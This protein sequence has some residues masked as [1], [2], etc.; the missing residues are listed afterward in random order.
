[1]LSKTLEFTI[2]SIFIR[3]REKNHKFVT[4]EH[5]L[6]ALVDDPETARILEACGAN[7]ER[8]RAG[9]SIYIDE[10]TP[11]LEPPY[12]QEIEPTRGFQRVLQRAIDQTQSTLNSEVNSTCVLLSLLNELDSQALFFLQEERISFADILT[13]SMH[14]LAR[15][16]AFQSPFQRPNPL[17]SDFN[18]FPEFGAMPEN[19][20]EAEKMADF[21]TN[22][23]EKAI[24]GKV[25]P[26]IGRVEEMQRTI[27]VLCRRSKNNPLLVGEAGVGKTAIA[28]GLA[29]MIVN[30]SVP[31]A[32]AKCI[33]Y[34]VDLGG[35]LA[36]TKY[37]G[38]FEKRFKST[39][40]SLRQEK[41]AII[42]I[43]EI[44]TLIGAGS[45]MGGSM[46]A[47]NLIKPLLSSGEIRCIGA[48]TLEECRQNLEKDNA[49]MRRFQKIDIS[50]PTPAETL[51]I[52][53]GLKARFERYH[54]ITYQPEALEKAVELSSRYLSDRHMPDKAIDIID[55]AGSF[56]KLQPVE[57]RHMQIGAAEIEKIMAKIARVPLQQVSSG[58]RSQLKSLGDRLKKSVFGQDHAIDQLVESI[59]LSRSGLS[60]HNKPIGSFLMIGPTGVGKTELTRQLAHELG[61]ELIRFDMSEYG[62]PHS[63]SRLIGAPPG[64][65]G[66]E[67]SGLL[68]EAIIKQPYS[69]LLLDEIE[70]AHHDIFNLL[71]QVMDYGFLTDNNGRKADFRHVIIVMTSN[72]GA[73]R[74]EKNSIGFTKDEKGSEVLSDVKLTFSPE[75]RNRLDAVIQF[76]Q[77]TPVIINQVVNRYLKELGDHLKGQGVSFGISKEAKAYLAEKG[78]DPVMGARPLQ[79]LINDQIKKRLADELLFGK[80]ANTIIN[81]GKAHIG[82]KGQDLQLNIIPQ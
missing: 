5:L 57:K 50:E 37:R 29:Q 16:T 38:D 40:N 21:V 18:S 60:M 4:V 78:Y 32:L 46:D 14:S 20:P 47:A 12:T 45:A 19:N 44:H 69:V 41:G 2:N 65:V 68:T 43:D 9:L 73:G 6:L 67:Q 81:K 27:Q 3:A 26:L 11:C 72:V 24:L 23:N 59:K 13:Q 64:Y 82:L 35:M 71:L 75:F 30:H 48:T 22:L 51:E 39:L 52:L 17:Q 15:Q 1:M 77:L 31:E 53:N 76:N 62:E 80:L 7:L 63:L 56:E 55:E 70:K 8:L 54:G 25:E 58:E 79:R 42:F 34:A 36:G 66:H 33:V 61:V 49:L 74:L 10:R 28:E